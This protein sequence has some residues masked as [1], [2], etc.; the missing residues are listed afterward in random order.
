MYMKYFI[1]EQANNLFAIY[2]DTGKESFAD[3][4]LI[5][6]DIANAKSAEDYVTNILKGT[7]SY[8]V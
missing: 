8:E 5:K 3:E 6:Y 1:T 2:T 7:F 4:T